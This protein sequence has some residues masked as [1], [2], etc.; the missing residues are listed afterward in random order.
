MKKS[1]LETLVN[2]AFDNP[3]NAFEFYRFLESNG[4]GFEERM[5]AVSFVSSGEPE[6]SA[7]TLY[8]RIKRNKTSF[9]F[10]SLFE[11]IYH[12]KKKH[13]SS[14]SREQA[15]EILK[16]VFFKIAGLDKRQLKEFYGE[17]STG[18]S[19]FLSE[20]ERVYFYEYV[21]SK[22]KT[23]DDVYFLR[24]CV[25]LFLVDY[26]FLKACEVRRMCLDVVEGLEVSEVIERSRLDN[27][28]IG[29]CVSALFENASLDKL[30]SISRAKELDLKTKKMARDACFFLTGKSYVDEVTPLEPV[31]FGKNVAVSGPVDIGEE[32]GKEIDAFD[33]VVKPN[34]KLSFKNKKPSVFGGRCDVS[35][36]NGGDPIT[37]F[38][39]IEKVVGDLSLMI[40]KTQRGYKKFKKNKP[41]RLMNKWGGMFNGAPNGIQNILYEVVLSR[42]GSV[43]LYNVDFFISSNYKDGYRRVGGRVIK[44]NSFACHCPFSNFTFVKIL[45]QSGLVAVSEKVGELLEMDDSDFAL[46]LQGSLG[47][48]RAN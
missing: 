44:S 24:R 18:S 28:F 23:A 39:D 14:V 29:F 27:S 25:D 10:F 1:M 21:R 33:L 8:N 43:V 17:V 41:S 35:Y 37:S 11:I 26:D 22:N 19:C 16:R 12:V 3:S 2:E 32:K 36:Y 13:S 34:Y 47:A 40:F 9:D 38:H 45:H 4:E 30:L 5:A 42:P 48:S 31:Y 7:G 15:L 46:A 20:K 6:G